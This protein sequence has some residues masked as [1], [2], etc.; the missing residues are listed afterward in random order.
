M[1][2]ISGQASSFVLRQSW[3]ENPSRERA[4]ERGHPRSLAACFFVRKINEMRRLQ[5]SHS[6]PK[7][8]HSPPSI[9]IK[10]AIHAAGA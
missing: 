6:N 7:P 5:L 2:S 4:K 8:S 3:E 9:I 1:K 10:T